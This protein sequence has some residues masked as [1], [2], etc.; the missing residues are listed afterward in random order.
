MEQFNLDTWLQ[1][2][3]RKVVT[4]AG[5]KVNILKYDAIT[6][7]YPVIVSIIRED[8]VEIPSTYTKEGHDNVECLMRNE[9]NDL[10]FADEEEELT[11]FER[12]A[13]ILIRKIKRHGNQSK[14]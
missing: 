14:G 2:K 10:F 6:P 4:R 9:K 1:N 11:E 7:M 8:G 13:R 5:R 12:R 3:S